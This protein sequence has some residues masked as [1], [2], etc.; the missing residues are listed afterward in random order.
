M[1]IYQKATQVK[2]FCE[3]T[4]ECK[5][6]NKFSNIIC[7]YYDICKDSELINSPC[8]ESIE[9]LAEVIKEENWTVN[10]KGD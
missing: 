4:P 5:R 10:I 7:P 3:N 8:F 2:K 1:T 6:S 9:R